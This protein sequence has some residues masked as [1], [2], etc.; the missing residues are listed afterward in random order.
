MKVS[1]MAHKKFN[2]MSVQAK[3][4]QQRN[5]D[6]L[7]GFPTIELQVHR[8][9]LGLSAGGF[10][11]LLGVSAQSVY[12]WEQEKARPRAERIA[13]LAALRSVR[14]REVAARLA[15]RGR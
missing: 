6:E 5:Q 4:R 7:L 11:R 10:G 13:K 15:T 8:S 12:N 2:E 9:Q 14:K 3:I 1:L